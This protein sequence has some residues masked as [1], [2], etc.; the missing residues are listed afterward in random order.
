M[1]AVE[2]DVVV[3]TD[4]KIQVAVV[5]VGR[6]VVLLGTECCPLTWDV[7]ELLSRE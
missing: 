3:G 4:S 6:P 1:V 5:V 2:V 7:E